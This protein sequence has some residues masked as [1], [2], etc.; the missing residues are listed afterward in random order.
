MCDR[1]ADECRVGLFVGRVFREPFSGLFGGMGAIEFAGNDLVINTR[2]VEPAAF[3]VK[4]GGPVALFGDD[5]AHF[6][7]DSFALGDARVG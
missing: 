6:L 4:P 3:F 1:R 2:C 5:F 7:A